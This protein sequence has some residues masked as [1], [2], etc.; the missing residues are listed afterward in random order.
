MTKDKE[1]LRKKNQTEAQ[2]TVEGNTSILEPMEDRI[3]ELKDETEIKI[4]KTEEMLV[5]QLKS[6][7]RKMHLLHQ[8]SKPENHGY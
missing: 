7:R 5:K 8:K 2:N 6:F 1:N 4:Q 3:S